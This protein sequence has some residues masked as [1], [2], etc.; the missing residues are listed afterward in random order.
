M[1]DLLTLN[2]TEEH[3]RKIIP[4]LHEAELRLFVSCDN[5]HYVSS[6]DPE[7]IE[8]VKGYEQ[9]SEVVGKTQAEIRTEDDW[10]VSDGHGN[11]KPYRD[12]KP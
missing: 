7:F 2:F 1:S 6:L 4:V 5:G 3:L 10:M 12:K 9:E 11:I 8:V